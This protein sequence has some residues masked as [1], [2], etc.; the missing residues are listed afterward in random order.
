MELL[1]CILC[2][3]AILSSVSRTVLLQSIDQRIFFQ[4]ELEGKGAN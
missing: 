3:A 1:N 4:H 2:L